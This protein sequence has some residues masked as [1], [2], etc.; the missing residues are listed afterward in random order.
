MPTV[1]NA[2][3]CDKFSFVM[4]LVLSPEAKAVVDDT[5]P[6]MSP[7][8]SSIVKTGV[9]FQEQAQVNCIN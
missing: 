3:A 8:G 1:T 6:S 4:Y 7:L 2:K 5:R 9:Y